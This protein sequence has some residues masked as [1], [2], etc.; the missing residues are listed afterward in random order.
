VARQYSP[1]SF[2]R[3]APNALLKH[4]LAEKGICPDM[5]C[6]RIRQEL[7]KQ[8]SQRRACQAVAEELGVPVQTVKTWHR[9]IHLNPCKAPT[10]PGKYHQTC[11][12]SDLQTLIEAAKVER[13]VRPLHFFP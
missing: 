7:E 4:Y 13:Q 5:A 9:Q 2:L 3:N 10:R 8:P 12:V 6:E 1:K 11:A